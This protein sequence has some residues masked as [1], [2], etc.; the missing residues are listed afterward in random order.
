LLIV[1]GSDPTVI[2]LNRQ[3][4]ARMNARTRLA[5]VP[6]A[7]H[8]FEEKGTLEQ[9]AQLAQLWFERWLL[10]RTPSRRVA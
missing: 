7:T 2:E 1:G 3:A 5:I 6:G 8:L 9:A 10:A 4:K